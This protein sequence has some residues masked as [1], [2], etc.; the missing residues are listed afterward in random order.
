M[1]GPPQGSVRLLF[2][3]APFRRSMTAGEA[4]L[5]AAN[6]TEVSWRD[7]DFVTQQAASLPLR[8]AAFPWK[9]DARGRV[10]HD[11]CALE[12][13][14]P[15]PKGRAPGPLPQHFLPLPRTLILCL[16]VLTTVS[17][18][19][20]ETRLPSDGQRHWMRGPQVDD[21]R[22]IQGWGGCMAAG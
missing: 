19:C 14:N 20:L 8:H 10:S 3:A 7:R 2:H 16:A 5:Q 12:M 15:T 17:S 11:P 18:V 4:A 9:H 6:D 13:Q 22:I 21:V 1:L